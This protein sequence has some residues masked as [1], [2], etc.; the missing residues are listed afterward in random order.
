M[1]RRLEG[2][3]AS[4]VTPLILRSIAY[5]VEDVGPEN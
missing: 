2:H 3:E 4:L 5:I 1:Y